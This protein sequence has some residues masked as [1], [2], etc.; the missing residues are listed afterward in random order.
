MKEKKKKTTTTNGV[1]E[2]V[3]R[4]FKSTVKPLLRE[5]RMR[6][7]MRVQ[8]SMKIGGIYIILLHSFEGN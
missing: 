4:H 6:V 2:Y 8:R 3:S 1:G 7:G 5:K